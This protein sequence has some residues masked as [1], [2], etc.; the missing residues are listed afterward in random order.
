[1]AENLFFHRLIAALLAPAFFARLPVRQIDYLPQ[2]W[3]LDPG[4]GKI[5][6]IPTCKM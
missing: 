6:Q 4:I 1:M 3:H 2:V 5:P